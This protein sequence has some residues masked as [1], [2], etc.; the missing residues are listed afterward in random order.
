MSRKS[1]FKPPAVAVSACAPRTQSVLTQHLRF[2]G[3]LLLSLL[4][5]LAMA[6]LAHAADTTVASGAAAVAI[7]GRAAVRVTGT[8]PVAVVAALDA[9]GDAAVANRALQAANTALMASPTYTAVP[10]GNVSRS[11]GSMKLGWPLTM[12]DYQAIGKS[13]KAPYAMTVVVNAGPREATQTNYTAVAELYDTKTGGLVG[14]GQGQAMLTPAEGTAA[15]DLWQSAVD[16][17]VSNAIASL[18][19]APTLTGVVV[20]RPAAYRARLSLGTIRGL[21]NGA[22]VEYLSNGQ[23]IAHGTV[24]DVGDAE[25]LATIVPESAVPGI[26]LNTQFRTVSVP[27]AAKAGLTSA[28]RDEQ[29]WNRFE[30]NFALSALAAALLYYTVIRD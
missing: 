29:E 12:A 30:R 11:L 14:H 6:R 21:R 13:V 10:A 28:Q 2:S 15:A 18:D 7:P 3:I 26:N 4:A 22:R 27:S 1:T 16:E 5:L 25:A 20:S 9:G 19:Q 17:A 24:I 23:P 8:T